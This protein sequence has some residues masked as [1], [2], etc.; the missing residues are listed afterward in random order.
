MSEY[1][2]SC[3]KPINV[4][5]LNNQ[6]IIYDVIYYLYMIFLCI[7]WINQRI[8]LYQIIRLLG[9]KII[10]N[11]RHSKNIGFIRIKMD[12][13]NQNKHRASASGSQCGDSKKRGH[14]LRKAKVT[15]QVF[16]HFNSHQI[17]TQHWS[18]CLCP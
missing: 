16:F 7:D 11:D 15:E 1:K 18:G 6:I 10:E 14:H 9:Y 17:E 8:I 13:R 4:N 2:Y 12:R 5:K 3:A